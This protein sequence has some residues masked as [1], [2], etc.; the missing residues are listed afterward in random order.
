MEVATFMDANETTV[1]F[2]KACLNR[3]IKTVN[4]LLKDKD[5]IDVTLDEMNTLLTTMSF[6]KDF[7]S[8]KELKDTMMENDTHEEVVKLLCEI[9]IDL[10]QKDHDGKT[11]LH[12]AVPVR[13]FKMF[14]GEFHENTKIVKILLEH[15]L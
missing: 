1:E 2:H 3:D 11:A 15:A 8:L 7:Y 4:N 12:L 5:K 9:G 13:G 10:E 6:I 14:G